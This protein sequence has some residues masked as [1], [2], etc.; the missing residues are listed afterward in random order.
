MMTIKFDIWKDKDGLTAVCM[1]GELG[2]ES[3]TFLEPK[4]K[5][6]HSF[7]AVSHFDTMSKYFEYIDWGVYQTE[8]EINK[9]PYNL[10]ELEARAKKWKAG[11]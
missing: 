5:I 1:A 11:N 10:N 2:E 4:S 8:F 6:I 3:R 7:Y 9:K